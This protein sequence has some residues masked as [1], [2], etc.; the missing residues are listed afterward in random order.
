MPFRS[1]GWWLE[2]LGV[3]HAGVGIVR[4]RDALGDIARHKLLDSVPGSGD[5]ATAF[6]FMAAAPTLWVGGR[7]L[8]SAEST[9]DVDAQR[10]AGVVLTAV[11]LM[12][13]AAIGRRPSGFWGVAAVGI[14]TLAGAGRSGCRS[15][16]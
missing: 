11:G 7:L 3:A 6:W 4:Y 2:F 8:R 12:G 13:S 9:G 1:P 15:A 16:T 14:A 10:T 5:K